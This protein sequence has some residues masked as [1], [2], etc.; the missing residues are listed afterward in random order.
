MKKLMF[1][2]VAALLSLAGNL[3][4]D[5]YEGMD[6]DNRHYYIGSRSGRYYINANGKKTYSAK[7]EISDRMLD[8][9][10]YTGPRG[11]RYY[12]NRNGNKT[13]IARKKGERSS[14]SYKSSSPKRSRSYSYKS[15]GSPR[16]RSYSYKSSRSTR[17]RSYSYKSSRSTRSRGYSYKSSRSTRWK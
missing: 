15:S 16:S 10:I 6:P 9:T 1:T 11:G 12:I 14:Y 8:D 3:Y 2:L 17:S 4:A 7:A 13:Y 5:T